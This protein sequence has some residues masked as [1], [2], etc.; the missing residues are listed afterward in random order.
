M[1]TSW[2]N[3]A[4]HH[5]L[6][7][8]NPVADESLTGSERTAEATAL[9]SRLTAIDPGRSVTSEGEGDRPTSNNVVRAGRALKGRLPRL[10]A[11]GLVASLL[12]VVLVFLNI[13]G[14]ESPT[15][16]APSS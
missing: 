7:L 3:Q 6:S 12:V 1:K 15:L 14:P 11:V 9:L 4:L 16:P 10:V 2:P 5:E 8:R 13:I